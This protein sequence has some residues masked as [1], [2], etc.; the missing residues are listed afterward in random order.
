[1]GI[2][3]WY[4]TINPNR[5]KEII[6]SFSRAHELPSALSIDG[7]AMH[8]TVLSAMMFTVLLALQS[9]LK[10]NIFIEHNIESL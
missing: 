2:S 4:A 1:M 8:L 9:N 6:I 3:E 7:K 10:W 5:C